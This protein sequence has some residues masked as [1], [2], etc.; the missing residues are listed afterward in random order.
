MNLSIEGGALPQWVFRIAGIYGLIVL[1]PMYFMADEF[2]RGSVPI[3][4]LEFYYGFAGTAIAWQFVFLLIA[5]DVRRYRLFIFPAILEKLAFSI[6]ALLLAARGALS[7]S[8][9][10][11][12]VIDLFLA[13]TFA[14]S[15]LVS[16]RKTAGKREPLN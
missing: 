16:V 6:P 15:Y 9:L 11:F 2:G 13:M 10:V 4:H 5:R 7:G 14:L 1:T 8:I 12:A 3:S